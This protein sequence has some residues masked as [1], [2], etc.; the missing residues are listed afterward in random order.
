MLMIAEIEKN[1]VTKVEIADEVVLTCSSHNDLYDLKID[2]FTSGVR[3]TITVCNDEKNFGTIN[4]YAADFGVKFVIKQNWNNRTAQFK[5]WHDSSA[6]VC[7]QYNIQYIDDDGMYCGNG[8]FAEHLETVLLWA[9]DNYLN[10]RRIF[11][12]IEVNDD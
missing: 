2:D 4:C 6:P 10:Y 3:E 11:E 5:I 9:Q 1:R 8:Y 7:R 12:I